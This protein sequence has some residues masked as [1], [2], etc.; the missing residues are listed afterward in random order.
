MFNVQERLEEMLDELER[1][2]PKNFEKI[3]REF[4]H[5][6][7]K[8]YIYTFCKFNCHVIPWEYKVY[9]QPRFTKPDIFPGT[10]L[11]EVDPI[12]GTSEIIW[13]L[14]H[15]EA[16]RLSQPG[17]IFSDPVVKDSIDKFM[18]GQLEEKFEKV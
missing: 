10:I 6:N 14:P 3:M 12:K 18:T 5:G 15:R 1:S 2:W 9:H 13:T 8:F 4:P 11:R 17:K 7:E 16:F